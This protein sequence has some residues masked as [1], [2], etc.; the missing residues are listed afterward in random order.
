MG[1]V[2]TEYVAFL[3]SDDWLMPQY[4]EKLVLYLEKNK[5][6]IGRAHV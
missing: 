3:D 2:E 1:L 6:Q 5:G 4:V